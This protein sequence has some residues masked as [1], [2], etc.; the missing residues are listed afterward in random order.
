MFVAL[1]LFD[2]QFHRRVLFSLDFLLLNLL[3]PLQVDF[4]RSAQTKVFLEFVKRVSITVVL[5]HWDLRDSL[6]VSI[7]VLQIA[8]FEGLIKHFN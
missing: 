7:K 6:N 2:E 3:L 5:A 4:E 8:V 1:Y